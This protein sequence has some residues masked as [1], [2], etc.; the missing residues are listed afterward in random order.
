M[1][2][3]NINTWSFDAQWLDS[4]FVKVANQWARRLGASSSIQADD[5]R[6]DLWEELYQQ[7]G[8]VE[9]I[10]GAATEEAARK[11]SFEFADRHRKRKL[12]AYRRNWPRLIQLRCRDNDGGGL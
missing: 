1:K 7:G 12:G 3:D 10:A 8:A 6:Q 9:V 2:H 5:I 11:A 4:I